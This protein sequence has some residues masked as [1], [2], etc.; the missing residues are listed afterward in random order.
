M[1]L[2][3]NKI[4]FILITTVLLGT[5]SFKIVS[6]ATLKTPG[7]ASYRQGVGINRGLVGWWT[8]D[9]ADVTAS[10][11]LD[12]SGQGNTCTRTALTATPGKIGQALNFRSASSS[13]C[14]TASY[15]L[16]STP[17]DYFTLAAWIKP[18][19][20][21][22]TAFLSTGEVSAYAEW[23]LYSGKLGWGLYGA[24]SY[25]V[26][27]TTIPA[28]QWSFVTMTFSTSTQ[29]VRVYYNGVYDGQKDVTGL[30]M[31]GGIN[32]IGGPY[33]AFFDG[34]MDDVR[35]YNRVL[36]DSEIKQ[37][38]SMGAGAKVAAT[39]QSQSQFQ[40]KGINSS[41]VGWWTFDGADIS[42][43]PLMINQATTIPEPSAEP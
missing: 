19:S 38:Y 5:G 14:V 3:T 35:I 39:P 28:N 1:K 8:F 10:T 4:F 37:L 15:I 36:S 21:G 32:T 30:I 25:Q 26:G 11:A 24:A 27:A 23:Q 31:Q 34:G 22:Q 41:L 7:T 18:S 2:F 13:K 20:S 29:R 40:G 12:K 43:L 16:G 6:A 9:G 33:S 17:P 42:G